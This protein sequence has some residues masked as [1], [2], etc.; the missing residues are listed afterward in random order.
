MQS[1][2]LMLTGRVRDVRDVRLVRVRRVRVKASVE[3]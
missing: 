1:V 3:A 2:H